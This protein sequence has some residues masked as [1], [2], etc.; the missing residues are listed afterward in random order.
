MS[1]NS[2]RR[3]LETPWN[4]IQHDPEKIVGPRAASPYGRRLWALSGWYVEDLNRIITGYNL[5]QVIY[6]GTKDWLSEG[7]RYKR[8]DC[9][10]EAEA[11]RFDWEVIEDCL[12][13]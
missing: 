4:G 13:R 1:A 5:N 12:G 2:L 8:C 9:V 3:L 6:F 10:K 11:I 7:K